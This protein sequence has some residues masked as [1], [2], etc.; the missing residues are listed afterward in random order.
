VDLVNLKLNTAVAALLALS[1]AEHSAPLGHRLSRAEIAALLQQ[2][3]L[4]AQMKTADIWR[5]WESGQRGRQP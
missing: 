5:S 2:T 3:G 1:V 4:D